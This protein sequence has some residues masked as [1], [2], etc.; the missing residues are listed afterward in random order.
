[1]PQLPPHYLKLTWGLG[2][3]NKSIEEI[4]RLLGDKSMAELEKKF[5]EYDIPETIKP[6]ENP[7]YSP[8]VA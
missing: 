1:M 5:K 3:R 6:V 8:E 7:A 2:L 4:F